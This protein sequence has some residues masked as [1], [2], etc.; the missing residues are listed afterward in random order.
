[1]G[2]LKIKSKQFYVKNKMYV[3]EN[4]SLQLVLLQQHHNP[5]IHS[6]PGYKAMYQKIQANYFWFDMAKHCKKYTSNCLTYR[7]TK[8]YTVQKQDLFNPLPIPNRKWMDL[9][10]DFVVKLPKCRRRNCVSQH[11]FVVIDRLTK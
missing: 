8:T 11:I 1:M 2:D 5:P 7:C 4:K 6:H 10:L 3:L 9:L